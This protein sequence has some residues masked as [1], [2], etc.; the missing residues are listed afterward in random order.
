MFQIK[1][2]PVEKLAKM[3]GRFRQA[4]KPEKL[5]HQADISA[6]RELHAFRAMMQIKLRGEGFFKRRRARPAGVDERA[7]NVK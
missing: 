5:A 2:V 1:S 4:M 6:A 3:L 7:I